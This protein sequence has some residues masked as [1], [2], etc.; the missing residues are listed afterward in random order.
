VVI[1]ATF[2]VTWEMLLM[3]SELSPEMLT[4]VYKLT[5]L[6][7]SIVLAGAGIGFAIGCAMVCGSSIECLTRK[8]DTRNSLMM[9]TM[10][11]TGFVSNFPFIVLALGAWFLFANPFVSVLKE[12]IS[13]LAKGVLP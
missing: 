8:P 10:I 4:L 3:S 13:S 11:F 9:D 6:S 7:I 5:A 2:H 1:S 12:M